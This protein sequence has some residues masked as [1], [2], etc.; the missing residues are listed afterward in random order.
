MTNQQAPVDNSPLSEEELE[1]FRQKLL[2]EQETA[3]TKMREIKE[4]LKSLNKNADDKQ[5]AQDHHHGDLAT[6]ESRR[7]TLLSSLEVQNE[8]LDQ[9]AVALDRIETG[10]YGICIDTGQPIQ[11]GRL[12]AKPYAIRSVGAQK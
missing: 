10:N 6:D 3:Q 1:H 11:K 8:K 4:S 7:S 2:N 12:E 5:S 9:I